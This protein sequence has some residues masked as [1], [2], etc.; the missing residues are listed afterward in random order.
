MENRETGTIAGGEAASGPLFTPAVVVA[1]VVTLLAMLVGLKLEGRVLFC[2]CGSWSPWI[3][4][5]DSRHCS[6]HLFDAYSASHV[7]H[8]VVFFGLMWV[9]KGAWSAGWRLWA[10]LALEAGWEVLENS[11]MVIDRYRTATIALGYT[12]DSIM[13][14]LFDVV[15]CVV[16]Y[17]IA[18]RVTWQWSVAFFVAVELVML[19]SIRDSLSLN[20][21]M[22]VYPLD[23]V[24][25]WQLG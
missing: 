1:C 25:Q 21:L 18:S 4:D 16:G 7:L 17:W 14:S 11:P 12:G 15:S 5:V 22:L 23:V 8:G 9:L 24:K 2:D 13:N 10:C 3:S 19:A 6:Q 20:V